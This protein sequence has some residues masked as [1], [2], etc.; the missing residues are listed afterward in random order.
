MMLLRLG[1]ITE[2]EFNKKLNSESA[3]KELKEPFFSLD[4]A[5][6]HIRNEFKNDSETLLIADE[7]NDSMGMNMAIIGDR[8]L[9]K[10]YMPDG[11]EQKNEY[12]IY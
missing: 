10:S 1:R 4:N 8:L 5:I 11:C 2:N 6:N 3:R 12:I 7:L 9:K